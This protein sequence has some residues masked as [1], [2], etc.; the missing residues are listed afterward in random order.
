MPR[1]NWRKG[2]PSF[3]NMLPVATMNSDFQ[4]SHRT[5]L[6][7]DESI[8][9]AVPA[10]IQTLTAIYDNPASENPEDWSNAVH[11][12]RRLL[13]ALADTLYPARADMTVTVNGKQKTIALGDAAYVNRLITF[14]D[15]QSESGSFK[16]IVG[17]HLRF[18]GERLDAIVGA[19][20]KGTHDDITTRAEADRYVIYTYMLVGDILSLVPQPSANAVRPIEAEETSL[21]DSSEPAKAKPVKK[22]RKQR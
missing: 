11:G 21:E 3:F 14:V 1:R 6:S 7:V 12:C 17:S 22:P 5:S 16:N 18:V 19:A 4:V 2:E 8:G 20:Q 10:A 9:A 13:K 15:E